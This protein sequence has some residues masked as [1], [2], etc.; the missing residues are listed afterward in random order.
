MTDALQRSTGRRNGF[1][2]CRKICREL[3]QHVCPSVL[4]HTCSCK[5]TLHHSLVNEIGAVCNVTYHVVLFETCSKL[6][7]LSL[8]VASPRLQSSCRCRLAS[9]SFDQFWVAAQRAIY[10]HV[11]SQATCTHLNTG[12]TGHSGEASAID[13][14]LSA[15]CMRS[16]HMNLSCCLGSRGHTRHRQFLQHSKYWMLS[17]FVNH[18]NRITQLE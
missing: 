1:R 17:R 2:K 13:H 6:V 3:A 16:K 7:T 14:S 15:P 12:G 4:C 11:T 5:L 18:P 9:E 10:C 8:Q